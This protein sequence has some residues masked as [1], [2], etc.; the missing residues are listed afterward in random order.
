MVIHP[1]ETEVGVGQPSKLAHG[2][3]GRARAGRDVIDESA[4]RGSVH[5]LLYPAR[6]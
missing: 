6:E 2:V 5:D 1:G 3:V 4:E